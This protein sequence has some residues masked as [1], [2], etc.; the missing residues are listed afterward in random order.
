VPKEDR[1][2]AS[3][4]QYDPAAEFAALAYSSGYY[5]AI[6]EDVH[7]QQNATHEIQERVVAAANRPEI[8]GLWGDDGR[9][10]S[11][12]GGA[13]DYYDDEA[14]YDDEDGYS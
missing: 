6:A 13:A 1:A 7:E 5:D 4:E 10:Q 3:D 12:D 14:G 8:A 2:L 11:G 9:E